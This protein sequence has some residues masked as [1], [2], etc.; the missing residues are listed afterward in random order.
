MELQQLN[1]QP[2]S[3]NLERM[4]VG[5][6]LRIDQI[7]VID[8]V[9]QV[10]KVRCTLDMDWEATEDDIRNAQQSPDTYVPQKVPRIDPRNVIEKEVDYKSWSNGNVM[11]LHF[12]DKSGKYY[13]FRRIE[14]FCVW[15]QEFAVKNFPFDV[16]DLVFVFQSREFNKSQLRVFVPS[17]LFD[18]FFR[19]ETTYLSIK[20]EWVLAYL[21]CYVQMVDWKKASYKYTHSGPEFDK[22]GAR[23]VPR[24][25]FRLQVERRAKP[26]MVRVIVWMCLL[27]ILSFFMFSI[28]FYQTA[29]R[30]GYAVTMV[31]AV[32]AFQFVINAIIPNVPYLTLVDKYNLYIFALLL[33]AALEVVIVGW[34]ATEDNYSELWEAVDWWFTVIYAVLFVITHIFWVMYGYIA[35]KHE[36][37][38]IGTN[39]RE[40]LLKNN[41]DQGSEPVSVMSFNRGKFYEDNGS[42]IDKLMGRTSS[43][44]SSNISSSNKRIMYSKK[45]K[46]FSFSSST[47]LK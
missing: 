19:I 28:P 5:L 8:T 37:S 18:N 33:C 11:K 4:E 12:D 39:W 44:T 47:G 24:M 13:N 34:Q 46:E 31:L 21:D 3:A 10:Y 27:G 9:N 1:S 26:I 42:V 29:D 2:I 32:V 36:S 30:L 17:H 38:K 45:Q 41:D 25:C 22:T 14:Y 20:A 15:T 43:N 7:D 40:T 35:Y 23:I 16:Q 6:R